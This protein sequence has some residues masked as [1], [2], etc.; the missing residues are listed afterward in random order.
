MVATAGLYEN[1]TEQTLHSSAIQ[2]L[3][4]DFN[5]AEEEIQ[6]LYEATL[7]R[8]KENARIKDFLAVLVIRNVKDII[9]KGIGL[10][11][12]EGN[13]PLSDMRENI[14]DTRGNSVSVLSPGGAV[15]LWKDEE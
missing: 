14:N 5:V 4:R 3:A 10:K 2:R 7:S 9:R 1:E 12:S 11:T 6:I 15:S 13:P 8:L